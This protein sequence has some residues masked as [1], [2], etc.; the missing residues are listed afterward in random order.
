MTLVAG[1]WLEPE[2][3]WSKLGPLPLGSTTDPHCLPRTTPALPTQ[4]VIITCYFPPEADSAGIHFA[5]VDASACVDEYGKPTAVIIHDH[6]GSGFDLATRK[7]LSQLRFSPAKNAQG[8][9]VA[10][11]SPPILVKFVR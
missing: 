1:C 6:L 10:G 11:V 3:G 9:W 7:C 2:S 4:D 8:Q 5:N